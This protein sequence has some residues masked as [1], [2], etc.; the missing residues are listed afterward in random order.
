MKGVIFLLLLLGFTALNAQDVAYVG[1]PGQRPG[2]LD[3]CKVALSMR[4]IKS[5]YTGPCVKVRRSSDNTTQDIGFVGRDFDVDAFNTFVGGGSGFVEVWYNQSGGIVNPNQ[6]T[7]ANQPQVTLNHKNGHPTLYFDGTDY[8]EFAASTTTFNFIHVIGGTVS[9]VGQA[10]TTA[11]PNNLY[12]YLGSNGI[13]ST[14][15]GFVVYYDDRASV[16][17]NNAHGFQATKAV[18]GRAVSAHTLANALTPNAYHFLQN[19]VSSSSA[20]VAVGW[21]KWDGVLDS[22]NVVQTTPAITLEAAA[23]VNATHNLWIGG[24]G[25]AASFPLIGYLAEV[26]IFGGINYAWQREIAANTNQYWGL[27]I[28]NQIDQDAQAYIDRVAAAGYAMTEAEKV[29]VNKYIIALKDAN[30][31]LFIIDRGLPIWG[32]TTPAAALVSFKAS[33][34]LAAFNSPTFST[35]GVDFNGTNQYITTTYVPGTM[36]G[37]NSQHIGF[38]C[39]ENQSLGNIDM[40]SVTS[41]QWG[42]ISLYSAGSALARMWNSTTGAV[43]TTAPADLRGYMIGSRTAAADLRLFW[44]GAQLGATQTGTLGTRPTHA[45]YI[46]ARNNGGTADAFSVRKCAMWSIGLGLTAAQ[47]QLDNQLTEQFFDDLGI[48]VQP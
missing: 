21:T 19:F 27:W 1:E 12:T 14:K 42:I 3:S 37:I 18:S 22:V 15:A 35:D 32:T 24:N 31:W 47:A 45:Y 6:T 36:S 10:G 26:T 46:G 48:G 41:A 38:Y 39:T 5:S 29:A 20:I 8:L 7:L 2:D 33:T 17:L 40:G 28:G 23:N 34:T 13:A 44:N 11:D 4:L 9:V 16:P 30:I 25:V 43:S